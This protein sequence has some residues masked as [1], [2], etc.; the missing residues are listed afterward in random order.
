MPFYKTF[1]GLSLSVLLLTLA[2]CD[3]QASIPTSDADNTTVKENLSNDTQLAE[4]VSPYL[5]KEFIAADDSAATPDGI[6]Q[7]VDANNDFALKMYKQLNQNASMENV[8]FSPYSVTS[9]MELAYLGADGQTYA[10]IQQVF[11][12]PTIDKLLPNTA[13]LYNQLNRPNA[14]YSLTSANGLWVQQQLAIKQ[15]YADKVSR[16][17]AAKVTP[18]DFIN[19]SASARQII[20]SA[21]SQQ[22]NKLIPQL[23]SADAIDQDTRS[24]LTNVLYFKGTWAKEFYDGSTE[25][26]PFYTFASDNS[27]VSSSSVEMMHQNDIFNYSE[28]E[29]VQVLEMDYQGEALSMMVALPKK[30]DKATMQQLAASLTSDKIVAWQAQLD[31]KDIDLYLPKFKLNLQYK[32]KDMLALMGMPSAFSDKA[33]FSKFSQTPLIF[34]NVIHQTVIEVDEVGTEAASVTYL[35]MV[36]VSDEEPVVPI[37][38]KA[39]HPFMFFIYDKQSKAILFMGQMVQPQT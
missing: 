39:D 27:D 5:D 9:A 25:T 34:N 13:A 20:N 38:F 10:E 37:T 15:D 7:I 31:Y 36:A 16:Y 19:N 6:K 8:V 17:L 11:D 24:I 18:V 2:S 33:N 30:S 35:G 26:A 21:I 3:R 22:T 1:H 28:D 14:N 12:Y 23:L 29:Q 4:A 32:M